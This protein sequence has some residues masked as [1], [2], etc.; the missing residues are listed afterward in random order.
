MRARDLAAAAAIAA[1]IAAA[2]GAAQDEPPAAP[3]ATGGPQVPTI[4]IEGVGRPKIPIAIPAFAA[5]GGDGRARELA[6]TLRDI[7]S[8]DLEFSGYF[9][10]IP[11]EYHALVRGGDGRRIPFKEW[12]G[13][14][15]DSLVL[16]E[17]GLDGGSMLLTGRVFDT[18]DQKTVVH[19]RYRADMEQQRL[20]AHKLSNEII[21]QYTG[22]PGLA[23]SRIAYVGNVGKA[24][25]I[26]VMDY[27][28]ARVK[29][30]TGNGSINLSPAWSPDGREIA[31]VSY[32]SGHPEL[33]IVNSDGELRRA[34]PQQ[35]GEL[36]SAPSWSPDGRLLAFSSSRDGNAE[37]YTLRVADG[38][39]TR[40][41]Q[42]EAIDTSP[43][44]SPGGREI[45]FT[46]DRSGTPQIYIMDAVGANVRRLSYE[47]AYCDAA[48]WSP[49]GDRIAFAARVPGGFDIFVKELESGRLLKLTENANINE[50]PRWSPDGRHLVF[51][52]NRTG[53]FDVY[54]MDADG[55][56]VRRLTRGGNSFSPSWS[57]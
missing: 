35:G 36:N 43:T 20:A 53:G 5:A 47:V 3:P 40:L 27:D 50:W 17:T 46:S 8:A 21:M 49:L 26:F 25:E 13:V 11:E 34:F 55:G 15:A 14:G 57:R 10:I 2:A 52:S 9:Q 33:M 45:A 19:K 39:L 12:V 4:R 48:S 6:V 7:V 37:I 41:T 32:R 18:G 42:N 54:V 22:Q 30:V 56:R 28:G 23:L 51:A 31:F 38:S 1:A 16:G 24:R 29:R 44:W